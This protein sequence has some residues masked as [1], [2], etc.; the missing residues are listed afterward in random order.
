MNLYDGIKS[1]ISSATPILYKIT[2]IFSEYSATFILYST[3]F[4]ITNFQSL[5][6]IS[7]LCITKI[8]TLFISIY[9]KT[10]SKRVR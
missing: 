10:N 8:T 1:S 2:F 4:I 5:T 7:Y 3:K 9:V 6:K